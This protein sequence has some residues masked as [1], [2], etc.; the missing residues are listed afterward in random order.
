MLL[1]LFNRTFTDPTA[2]VLSTG[3]GVLCLHASVSG[4]DLEASVLIGQLESAALIGELS[5]SVA[6]VTVSMT[7]TC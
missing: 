2:P 7:Y 5:A 1:L 6:D 4:D 3:Y